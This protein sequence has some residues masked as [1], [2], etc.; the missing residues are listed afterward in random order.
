MKKVFKN[1]SYVYF[2]IFL[3]IEEFYGNDLKTN[4]NSF[5][6]F[7]EKNT[8]LICEFPFTCGHAFINNKRICNDIINQLKER[9]SNLKEKLISN[10]ISSERT[11]NYQDQFISIY[12]VRNNKQY[13]IVTTDNNSNKFNEI[14]NNY[15]NSLISGF[16]IPNDIDLYKKSE[17][18]KEIEKKI[19]KILIG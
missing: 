8:T 9:N 7:A 3:I 10:K 14:L 15:P 12:I 18:I 11:N 5:K 16:K 17:L 2:F 1:I 19:I 6:F 4:L 13:L